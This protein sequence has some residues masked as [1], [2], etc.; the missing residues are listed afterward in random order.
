[1]IKI[2]IAGATG[3]TGSELLRILHHHP[4]ASVI[5]ITSERSAGCH[6]TEIFPQFQDL[7]D[8]TFESLQEDTFLQD[9]DLLFTALPH[10]ESMKVMQ[11]I[12]N[13]SVRI[14]DLSAD[15]RLHDRNLYPQW[16]HYEH[17]APDLPD[18]WIYGLPE[19]HRE[20][21]VNAK[22][23]AN[24]GCYPTGAILGI[25][26]LIREEKVNLQGMI[27]DAKSGVTGAGKSPKAHLHFPEVNESLT[28]YRI[29]EHQHTP[30][31]EQ[32]IS[33]SAGE[34]VTIN[35]TPHL[36]PMNRGVYNTIYATLLEQ[37]STR[38]LLGIYQNFYQGEPFVRVLP[39]GVLPNT[40]QVRGTNFCDIGLKADPRTGRVI[41]TSAID[42]LVK[43]AAGQ[44]VQNMNLM[45]GFEETAGLQFPALS[46]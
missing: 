30:E 42:N 39:E 40:K 43:G 25:T 15:F 24:P 13:N 28:A 35:F 16:Y 44:A 37:V 41:I 6:I 2:A 18:R 45:M 33:L 1:M 3:Y 14:I 38:D 7:Y 4:E 29:G 11:R 10:G 31:I 36:I 5:R 21:I 32:E 17:T 46:P 9:V 27:F 19:L 23:I 20:R 34:K 22:R 26:P 12:T 8:L